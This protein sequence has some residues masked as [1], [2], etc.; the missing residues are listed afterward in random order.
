MFW[1]YFA[2][3][4]LLITFAERRVF[5]FSSLYFIRGIYLVVIYSRVLSFYQS[6]QVRF[7]F[8]VVV[9][10]WWRVLCCLFRFEALFRLSAGFLPIRLTTYTL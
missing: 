8:P 1:K 2:D 10:R 3:C 4:V 7:V 9:V 5:K 6:N